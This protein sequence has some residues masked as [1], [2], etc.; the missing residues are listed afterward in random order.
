MFC[1]LNKKKKFNILL[2]G[3]IYSGQ[4]S[5][6]YR[7]KYKKTFSTVP[8][9]S[10]N[11]ET[12]EYKNKIFCF[13]DIGNMCKSLTKYFFHN[14]DLVIYVVNSNTNIDLIKAEFDEFFDK[15]TSD[16]SEL[17]GIPLLILAN[18]QDLFESHFVDKIDDILNIHDRYKYLNNIIGCSAESGEG[19]DNIIKWINHTLI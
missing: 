14:T 7:I 15:L 1:C 13:W 17:N 6:L 3:N 2:T 18:K 4:T 10:Y 9:I 19:I 16:D 8:T 5:L 11:Y 12:F